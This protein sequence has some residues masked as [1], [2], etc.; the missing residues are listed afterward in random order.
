MTMLATF[1]PFIY[2]NDLISAGILVAFSMTNSCLV[3]LRCDQTNNAL[4]VYLLVFNCLCFITGVVLTRVDSLLPS[5]L[6]CCLTL[7][8]FAYM[9]KKCPRVRVFGGTMLSGTSSMGG[10]DEGFFETPLVPFVPCLGIFVNWYL[11]AQQSLFGLVLLMLY[12]GVTTLLYCACCRNSEP[13]W[14]RNGRI[15][16]G[17]DVDDTESEEAISLQRLT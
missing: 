10:D 3:L 4:H 13:A 16:Q 15:M 2:L 6:C 14:R 12:L 11:V 17:L 5:V 1:V 7:G 8:T 9:W